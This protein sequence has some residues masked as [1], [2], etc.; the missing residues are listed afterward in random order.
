MALLCYGSEPN[1]YSILVHALV[2]KRFISNS[3]TFSRN[4]KK[5]Q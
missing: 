2:L 3:I 5:T 1:Q 4:K